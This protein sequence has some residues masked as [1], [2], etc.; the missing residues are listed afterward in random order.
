MDFDF[1]FLN[2]ITVKPF[3]GIAVREDKILSAGCYGKSNPMAFPEGVGNL[4]RTDSYRI[5]E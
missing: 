5:N 4:S 3:F 2:F 1:G